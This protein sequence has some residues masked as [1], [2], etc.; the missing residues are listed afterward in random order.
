M[1]LIIG[2][3]SFQQVFLKTNKLVY[4]FEDFDSWTL[5]TSD[6]SLQIKCIVNKDIE[7]PENNMAFV[8]RYFNAHNIIKVEQVIEREPVKMRLIQE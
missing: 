6:E 7:N 1:I 5:Y 4:V 3:L 8:D 2:W